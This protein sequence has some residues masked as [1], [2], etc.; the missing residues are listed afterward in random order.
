MQ[1]FLRRATDP[2]VRRIVFAGLIVQ[3]LVLLGAPVARY[4]AVA[5]VVAVVLSART[6]ADSWA[7]AGLATVVGAGP[8]L[9]VHGALHD[10][11]TAPIPVWASALVLQVVW[12]WATLALGAW[13]ATRMRDAHAVRDAWGRILAVASVTAFVAGVL[14]R[15]LRS[16]V[17][18]SLRLAWIIGEED[19]AQIVGVA[20][21][22]LVH[23]PGG[24]ELASDFGTAFVNMP[25]ALLRLL[26]G[27]QTVD[28][29]ARLEALTLFVVSTITVVL[30]AGLAMAMISALPFHVHSGNLVSRSDSGVAG[31]ATTAVGAL[32][33][34][35][36]A[37][38]GFSLL[39]VL[40]MRT[41]FL[42]FVWG[43]ALILLATGV[44]AS[45][46][47]D[48]PL[49]A[50]AVG[51]LHLIGTAILLLSSWPFI[52]PALAPLFLLLA[53]RLPWRSI[54]AVSRSRPRT[55][56]APLSVVLLVG[57]LGS[58]LLL[59]GPVANVLSFGV[60]LLTVGGSAIYADDV[61]RS[62]SFVSIILF[63][64]LA[65]IPTR[66]ARSRLGAAII[67]AAPVVGA[68][69]LYL[70]L[71]LAAAILT[72][73]QLGYAGI[74]LLY[75]VVVLA[76]IL[77]LLGLSWQA[78]RGG[79]PASAGL[80]VSVIALHQ[81][82]PVAAGY[83]Q[84]QAQTYRPGTVHAEA[85]IDAIERSSIDVAIRCLPAPG[86]TVTDSTRWAA[87]FCARW[88]E[89]AFNEG[90]FDGRRADLLFAPDGTFEPLVAR[91]E[92]ENRSEYLFAF[93][94]TMGPGWA[95]WN[96]SGGE[97]ATAP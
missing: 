54:I 95:G 83:Q 14:G 48:A 11:V 60:D 58:F 88:V 39:V 40:P 38:I 37:L 17:D 22:V 2:V 1:S 91:I 42:T 43:I 29:D 4:A 81:M 53:G 72:E 13:V 94:M 5:L 69:S 18:P 50:Q 59:Q 73:G 49:H 57:I 66:S 27:G 64:V 3:G 77:G 16:S 30:I 55:V 19:N 62:A 84:W 51:L 32:T 34:A 70:G 80:L 79:L 15:L 52:L 63:V 6:S 75:G 35:L 46:P 45:I 8:A 20:R 44:T 25:L 56:L 76:A 74:K 9:I 92:D 78:A 68:G 96:G 26:G 90:R 89:D 71:R 47:A 12:T 28:A 21:E 93:R 65:L 7:R 31:S 86:T 24:A 23:G 41:G 97:S 82:S 36:A 87:Y 33:T 10:T 67:V 61:L 85:V